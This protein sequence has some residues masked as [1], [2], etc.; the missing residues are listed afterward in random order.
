MRFL[1]PIFSL[2]FIVSCNNPPEPDL[3]RQ[4]EG[5]KLRG[6]INDIVG[7][8]PIVVFAD[9][10]RRVYAA[11]KRETESSN[12]LLDFTLSD[13][14]FPVV[15]TDQ[16]GNEYDIFGYSITEPEI[17]LKPIEQVVGYWF[18]FPAFYEETELFN[19]EKIVNSNYPTE[20]INNDFVFAGSFRDGIPSIDNPEFKNLTG[21]EFI[22]DPFYANLEDDELVTVLTIGGNNF[23]YPHRI[24]EYHEVANSVHSNQPLTISYCPLTGTS[25]VWSRILEGKEVEFG[26]S[27]LLYNNNLILYDRVSETN[28]SQILG[29]GVEG[30]YKAKLP[31]EVMFVEMTLQTARILEGTSYYLTTNTGHNFDYSISLYNRY[32]TDE[33][34][35]FPL[36]YSDNRFHPKDRLLGVPF[37]SNIKI[38]QFEDFIIE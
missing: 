31:T 3:I 11:F 16:F 13:K 23:V 9:S 6:I 1:I 37:G 5:P 26:V 25:K 7:D 36:L 27:G 22:D 8:I 29:V 12:E 28:W 19:S 10:K 33:R 32:K 21:K 35:S 30:V 15:F 4:P 18:F 20:I 14:G 34:V 24:L 38:Y 17:R 2:L